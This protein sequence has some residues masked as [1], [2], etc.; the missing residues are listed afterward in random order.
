MGLAS[1]DVRA[2]PKKFQNTKIHH[3]ETPPF[4]CYNK[5]KEKICFIYGGIYMGNK[6]KLIVVLFIVMS[7][8]IIISSCTG[9]IEESNNEPVSKTEFVLG[10]VATIKLYDNA[11]DEVFSE[12]FGKLKEIED[13]MTINEGNSEVMDINSRAGKDLARVSDETFYVIERGK[14]FSELSEGKFEISIGP[15]VKLWN[16]GTKEAKVPTEEEIE[17]R[18]ALVDFKN[19]FLNEDEKSVML[20]KEGMVLDLGGIAKGFGV[21]EV[22]R[23]LKGHGVKHAIINLGGNVF[24]Y[25]NKPDGTPWKVGVQ[26]PKSPR[27]DYVGIAEVVNK[28]VVTSGIYERYFEKEGKRYH[29]ILDPSTGYPVE[30]TLAG[31]SIISESSIDADS[32][33]TAAFALGIDKGIELI[34]SLENVEAVF[35]TKNSEVHITSGLKKNFKLTDLN[36]KL[37]E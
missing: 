36:F 28:T 4:I 18:K 22:V 30:N 21:D 13:K 12:A 11:A 27:G 5:L 23:I 7:I 17:R 32:L 31:V 8:S 26:N 37:V 9:K 14:Y 15:L 34:E 19:I 25:G 1:T 6:G 33:S 24:A 10:T 20:K 35:V 29:H 16:I 3:S 2:K